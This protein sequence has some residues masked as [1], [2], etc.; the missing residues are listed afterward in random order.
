[1]LSLHFRSFYPP[2]E[3]VGKAGERA[4]KCLASLASLE[5]YYYKPRI[6]YHHPH[7]GQYAVPGS[8]RSRTGKT[9][10][11]IAGDRSGTPKPLLEE[12]IGEVFQ[13]RLDT[14]IVLAG[15]EYETVGVVDLA[16]EL[17]KRLG[18]FACTSCRASED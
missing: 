10:G 4:F 1:M 7:F 12:M 3:I 16:G 14:P 18:R 8:C 13:S 5:G 9:S 2:Q 15:D 17:L 11:R 6:D